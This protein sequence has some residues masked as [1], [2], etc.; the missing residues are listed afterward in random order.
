MPGYFRVSFATSQENIR[1]GFERI[2]ESLG[3]LL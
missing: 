3:R 2:G 1:T